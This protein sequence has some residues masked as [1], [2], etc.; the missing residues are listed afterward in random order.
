MSIL[1][2]IIHWPDPGR[3]QPLFEEAERRGDEWE[4]PERMEHVQ[5]GDL[6]ADPVRGP[7]VL[8]G[9]PQP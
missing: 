1:R 8:H 3:R 5:R 9:G 7:A 4:D 2:F 6:S